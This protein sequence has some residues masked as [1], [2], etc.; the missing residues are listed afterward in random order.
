[1]NSGLVGYKQESKVNKM[2]NMYQRRI[3]EN[4]KT[5]EK[6]SAA[7]WAKKLGMPTKSFLNRIWISEK[8]HGV[9][10]ASCFGPKQN[11]AKKKKEEIERDM[12]KEQCFTGESTARTRSLK[13]EGLTTVKLDIDTRRKYT[14]MTPQQ[15]KDRFKP[16]P[17]K[18]DL[19]ALGLAVA[20]IPGQYTT[21]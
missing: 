1:M 3:Y 7:G 12:K 16:Q 17:F 20:P 6:H 5:G 11:T 21:K 8:R 19:V 4:P 13:Y 10:V 15:K 2:G 14:R 9:I 18:V